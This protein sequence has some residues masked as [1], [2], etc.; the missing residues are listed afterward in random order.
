MHDI[1]RDTV[2]GAAVPPFL[3]VL[4]YFGEILVVSVNK[5]YRERL[6]FQ[7]FKSRLLILTENKTEISRDNNVVVRRRSYLKSSE[8]FPRSSVSVTRNI[9]HCAASAF[10]FIKYSLSRRLS[11]RHTTM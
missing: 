6:L 1:V 7:R 2:D 11:L 10:S 8:K 3:G 5:R 4:V 9:D